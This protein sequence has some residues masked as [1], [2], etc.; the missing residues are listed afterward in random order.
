MKLAGVED[1]KEAHEQ[2][3]QQ[4]RKRM[5]R[6]R[7]DH[8]LQDDNRVERI[9]H[10][11]TARVAKISGIYRQADSGLIK[12]TFIDGDENRPAARVHLLWE[13]W[14]WLSTQETVN[15]TMDQFKRGMFLDGRKH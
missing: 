1:P 15:W 14:E 7:R 3:K 4:T 12:V 11:T 10:L 8:Q 9:L 13:P 6:V 5:R 2:G